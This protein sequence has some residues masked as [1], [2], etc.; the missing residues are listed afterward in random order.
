MSGDV[1]NPSTVG[2]TLCNDYMRIVSWVSILSTDP[3]CCNLCSESTAQLQFP[4]TQIMFLILARMIR[5]GKD[6]YATTLISIVTS[7][8]RGSWQIFSIVDGRSTFNLKFVRSV[9]QCRRRGLDICIHRNTDEE[10]LLL[11]Y[12]ALQMTFHEVRMSQ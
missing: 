5:T 9:A 6:Q 4:G 7:L 12:D 1:G 8:Y 3:E 10:H 11:A 2:P